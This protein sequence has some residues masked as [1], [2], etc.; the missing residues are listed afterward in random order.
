MIA[1][2]VQSLY[3]IA[4]LLVPFLPDTSAQMC[5]IIREHRMPETPLFPRIEY[6]V[7]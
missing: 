3:D 2:L 1:E 5:R 6:A 7:L 4:V